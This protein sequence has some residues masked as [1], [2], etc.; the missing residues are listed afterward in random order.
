MKTNKPSKAGWLITCFW[1]FCYVGLATTR[2]NIK[3][4]FVDYI[5]WKSKYEAN[6]EIYVLLFQLNPFQSDIEFVGCINSF[7]TEVSHS[8][9]WGINP[10]LKNTTPPLPSSPPPPPKKP[11]PPFSGKPPPPLKS[12]NCPSLLFWELPTYILFFCDPP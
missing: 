1:L 10:A 5:Y 8:V 3:P 11:P 7:M 2:R 4:S 12:A 9:H 6:H